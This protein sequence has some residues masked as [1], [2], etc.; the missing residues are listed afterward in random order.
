M[1][2]AIIPAR[3]KSK[4]IKNKN[5]INFSGKPIIYW[6]ITVAKKSKLFSNIFVST[7][8]SKIAKI[9]KK[10]GA[11]IPFIR[12]SNISD[13]KSG[14]IEVMKH[15][16]K[17]LE[18]KKIKFKYLCC[19]FATAPFIN[20]KIL[21]K[22]FNKLKKGKFDFVFGAKK[23]NYN[24]LRAFY[25]NKNKLRMLNEKF[26]SYPS[27]NLPKAY[28]DAG[29]FYWGTKNAWKK[30]KIIFT[31]NSSFIELDSKKFKDINTYRDLKEAKKVGKN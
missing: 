31:N 27:Q 1:K 5:I 16:I 9:S 3:G 4:R 20:K 17:N 6:P 18:K 29:Q 30:K 7:D 21:I 19:I 14:I 8:D 24:H 25:F 15:A 23:I 22:S 11:E 2:V 10:F 28:I 26:Y 13:D 12:P